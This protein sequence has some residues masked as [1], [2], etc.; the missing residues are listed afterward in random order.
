LHDRQPE[1]QRCYEDVV[2]AALLQRGTQGAVDPAPVRLDA[3]LEINPAGDVRDVKLDGA[4]PDAMRDC[5]RKSILSWRFPS[6]GGPT[7]LR[8]PIVFQ[9]NIVK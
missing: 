5:A 3:A 2:V 1:L 4:A 9:P 8:V 7:S 6:S